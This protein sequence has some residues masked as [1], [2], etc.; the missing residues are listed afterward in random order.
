MV[1]TA[2]SYPDEDVQQIAANTS[3]QDT[4]YSEMFAWTT[5][6]GLLRITPEKYLPEMLRVHFGFLRQYL[7]PKTAECEIAFLHQTRHV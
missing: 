5:R 2:T 3:E 7:P 1:L 4:R 6:L